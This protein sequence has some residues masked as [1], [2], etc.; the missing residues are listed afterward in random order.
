MR[1]VRVRVLC[2]KIYNYYFDIVLVRSGI[3]RANRDAKSRKRGRGE[4]RDGVPQ[5]GQ[6]DTKSTKRYDLCWMIW[7]PEQMF[8]AIPGVLDAVCVY[9]GGKHHGLRTNVSMIIPKE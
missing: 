3:H 7:G 1:R 6:R 8:R 9:V 5:S 4:R 2:K